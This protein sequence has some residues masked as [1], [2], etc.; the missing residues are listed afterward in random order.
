MISDALVDVRLTYKENE[1]YHLS[2]Y[3]MH[4]WYKDHNGSNY[5]FLHRKQKRI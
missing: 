1:S 2:Y 3:N 5:T 4:T